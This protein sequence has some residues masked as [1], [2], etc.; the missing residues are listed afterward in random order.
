MGCEAQLA[1]KCLFM[2]TFSRGWF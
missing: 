2:T 1:C